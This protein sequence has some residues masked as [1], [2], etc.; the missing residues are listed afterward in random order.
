[1]RSIDFQKKIDAFFVVFTWVFGI[2][3]RRPVF[4]EMNSFVGHLFRFLYF[5]LSEM[6][7]DLFRFLEYNSQ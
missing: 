3:A 1:M 4:R 6:K 2:C 7:I 5:V